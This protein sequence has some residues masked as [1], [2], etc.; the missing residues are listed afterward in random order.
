MNLKRQLAELL[1]SHGLATPTGSVDGALNIVALVDAR[2]VDVPE[3]AT[4]E[5]NTDD[6]PRII[7]LN[8]SSRFGEAL[9]VD[10]FGLTQRLSFGDET[11]VCKIP[12][13]AIGMMRQGAISVCC[14]IAEAYEAAEEKPV[15]RHLRAVE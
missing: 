10:D 14:D 12:W 4:P 11:H 7:S 15:R 1:L 3:R 8:F 6:A 13:A 2:G 5:A 9:T